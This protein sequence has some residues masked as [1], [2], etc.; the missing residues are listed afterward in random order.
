MCVTLLLCEISL[1]HATMTDRSTK[2]W[3]GRHY[4]ADHIRG[5]IGFLN[6]TTRFHPIHRPTNP[7]KAH[8]PSTQAEVAAAPEMEK[9]KE[10]EDED[11]RRQKQQHSHTGIYAVW[12]SRDN[13]KGRHALALTP[14]AAE[15]RTG[16]GAVA[17]LPK[18][19][20]SWDATMAGIGR[21][22]MKF[23]IWDVS[24]DVAIIFTLGSVGSSPLKSLKKK[25]EKT[26]P[27]G[28]RTKS[29]CAI[30]SCHVQARESE[31]ANLWVRLSGL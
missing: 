17:T 29:S 26:P 31:G 7:S 21:M 23:P 12:R 15:A 1:C 13:R 11:E 27:P 2:H 18:R 16:G 10:A 14:S 20:D 6:P 22:L 5:P 28:E 19:T 8:S 3:V 30:V 24:Y 9:E 25:E 4:D